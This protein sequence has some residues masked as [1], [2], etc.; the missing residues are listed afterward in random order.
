MLLVLLQEEFDENAPLGGTGDGV[1]GDDEQDP[2]GEDGG[3]EKGE[4]DKAT[5][6]TIATG[7]EST[8]ALVSEEKDM[9]AEFA[10]WQAKVGP[11]F[12]ALESAL[13]PVERFALK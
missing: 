4:K 11:D 3:G 5:K 12:H 7:A 10:S 13:K 8:L 1:E 2:H 6:P 9:E